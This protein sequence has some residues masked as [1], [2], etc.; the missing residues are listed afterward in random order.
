M[1]AVPLGGSVSP[2]GGGHGQWNGVQYVSDG[3]YGK[4]TLISSKN[5]SSFSRRVRVFHGLKSI[6]FSLCQPVL[7]SL[8]T[9][10]APQ[11]LII[12]ETLLT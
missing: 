4:E 2:P 8:S 10:I 9:T 6:S 5:S 12:S 3:S 11:S 7:C 1:S